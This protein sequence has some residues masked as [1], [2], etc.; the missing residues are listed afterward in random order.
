MLAKKINKVNTHVVDI[1]GNVKGRDQPIMLMEKAHELVSTLPKELF[2]DNEV[3]FFD[4]FCKAGEI[5]LACAFNSCIHKSKNGNLHDIEKIQKELYQ[6]KKYFGLAPDERHHRLSLRTFLGNENSHKE[7]F[8]HIIKD[9]NYLSEKDGKLDKEKYQREFGH[10]IDYIKKQT[11]KKKIIAV[12]NPP[13][14]ESDG[15]F[16]KSAKS[17]YD[18]F[19]ETLID[20]EQLEEFLLVIPARWFGGGKGLNN[21]R[22]RIINSGKV[23]NLRV[24]RNSSDVFPTVDINGGVCYL[25]YDKNF[26]GKTCY[27]DGDNTISLHLNQYDIITDD[28]RGYEIVKKILEKWEGKFIGDVA[29]SRNP[30]GLA[31][32]YFKENKNLDKNNIHA[33]RCK[34]KNGYKYANINHVTS[35]SDKINFWKVICPKAAGG[36]KGKRRATI[37][38]SVID[39]LEPGVIS[40][41]TYNVLNTFKTKEEAM[42]FSDYLKTDFSRYMVGLRKITQDIPKDRWNWVP[43]LDYSRAW[44][45]KKLFKKF[46][47]TQEEQDHIAKKIEEWS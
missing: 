7:E 42:N 25:H 28:P 12:G 24:F 41:E 31:S 45:D 39:I 10:M 26:S 20:S 19:T 2:L 37:P 3:V 30:Y 34:S 21:F 29:W 23:K 36:S 40:T 11:G 43:Y 5:L 14:Q 6:S 35:H 1:L 46:G 4:P 47:I 38:L 9:G 16:G 17:I 8:N 44:T 22:R 15:G 32:N 33:I 18:F 27:T 13:Y